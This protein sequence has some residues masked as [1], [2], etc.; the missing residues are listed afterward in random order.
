MYYTHIHIYIS[1]N[2]SNCIHKINAQSTI[3]VLEGIPIEKNKYILNNPQKD[4]N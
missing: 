3:A 1:A 4:C 2:L